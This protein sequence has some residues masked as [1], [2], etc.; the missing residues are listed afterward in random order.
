MR[1]KIQLSE[2]TVEAR[3]VFRLTGKERKAKGKALDRQEEEKTVIFY[4]LW[5]RGRISFSGTGSLFSEV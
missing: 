5:A 1:R 4:S 3:G 2:R